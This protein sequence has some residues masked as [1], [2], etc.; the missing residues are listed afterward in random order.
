MKGTVVF[1]SRLS[2]IRWKRSGQAPDPGLV[3]DG[4][5]DLIDGYPEWN[6]VGLCLTSLAG[7]GSAPGWLADNRGIMV[8]FF[9]GGTVA[10]TF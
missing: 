10:S 2:Q 7:F 4:I 3:F 8:G 1:E 5:E 9:L 6:E